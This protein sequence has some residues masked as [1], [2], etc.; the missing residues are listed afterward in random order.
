MIIKLRESQLFTTDP[1]QRFADTYRVSEDIYRELW[2]RYN[3]LEYSIAELCEVYYIKVGRPINK[4]TMSEWMFRGKVYS[5]VSGK[6]KMGAQAV[7]SNVFEE[8]EQRVIKELLKHL[9]SGISASTKSI[10]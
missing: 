2:K 10:A 6:I 8:L 3:L 9:K 7:N 1:A 5:K 4:R